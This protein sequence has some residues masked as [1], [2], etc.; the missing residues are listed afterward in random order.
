M[1]LR[2][3]KAMGFLNLTGIDIV[4]KTTPVVLHGEGISLVEHK[5]RRATANSSIIAR[6]NTCN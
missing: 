5:T 2:F 3:I 4:D 6:L 1:R